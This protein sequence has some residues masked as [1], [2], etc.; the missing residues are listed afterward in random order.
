VRVGSAVDSNVVDGEP[1]LHHVADINIPGAAKPRL[2]RD[3]V[4]ASTGNQSGGLLTGPDPHPRGDATPAV[5]E[6]D[7]V[8]ME[9]RV[10]V[11]GNRNEV[12]RCRPSPLD[13][14]AHEVPLHNV[15][16][17]AEVSARNRIG[18][19]RGTQRDEIETLLACADLA[20]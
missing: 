4:E 8:L 20:C 15:R 13:N 7:E 19:R 16:L 11:I 6:L 9:V 3:E 18:L 2:E 5:A 17:P 10:G 1:Q 14:L 12:M